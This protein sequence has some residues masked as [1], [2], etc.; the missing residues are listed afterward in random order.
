MR[1]EQPA[2]D[3]ALDGEQLDSQEAVEVPARDDLSM[4][5]AEPTGSKHGDAETADRIS[6][7]LPP[8]E[9]PGD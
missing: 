3:D 4:I 9:R 5:A 2:P 6:V 8:N 7:Q 1:P